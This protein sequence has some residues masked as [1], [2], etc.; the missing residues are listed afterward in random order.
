MASLCPC[1][2]ATHAGIDVKELVF[3]LEFRGR[4]GAVAG[5]EGKRRARSVAPSQTLSS[6]LTA[7]GIQGGVE[8]LPG[9]EAVLEAEVSIVDERTFTES[10][11]IRYGRAG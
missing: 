2:P 10:G 6:V 7:A 1:S 11:T 3:A 4:A 9:D 5:A 8:K